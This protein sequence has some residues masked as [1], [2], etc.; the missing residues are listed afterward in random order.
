MKVTQIVPQE[1]LA[2]YAAPRK[3]GSRNSQ[4]GPRHV[5]SCDGQDAEL[6]QMAPQGLSRL[7]NL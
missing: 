4:K 3:V 6:I 7:D 1:G 5:L 2:L